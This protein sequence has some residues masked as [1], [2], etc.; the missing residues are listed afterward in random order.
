MKCML[1]HVAASR[2]NLAME[3]MFSG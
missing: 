2:P 1:I 3:Y